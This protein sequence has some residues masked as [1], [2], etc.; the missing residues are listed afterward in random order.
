MA[1]CPTFGTRV[2][3]GTIAERGTG[4]WNSSLSGNGKSSDPT[5]C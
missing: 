2:Y 3:S 1:S 4:A 5:T